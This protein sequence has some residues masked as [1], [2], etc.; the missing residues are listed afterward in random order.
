MIK[1]AVGRKES[2]NITCFSRTFSEVKKRADTNT[3]W[4]PK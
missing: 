4:N 2:I 1:I 3:D